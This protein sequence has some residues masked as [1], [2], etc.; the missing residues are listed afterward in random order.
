[1]SSSC[2]VIGIDLGTEDLTVSETDLL[3]A[4]ESF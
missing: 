2:Y 3:I 4:P 1:M